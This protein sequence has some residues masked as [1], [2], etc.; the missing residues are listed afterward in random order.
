MIERC[1][2]VLQDVVDD[3]GA[4]KRRRS[5]NLVRGVTATQHQQPAGSVAVTDPS[6]S[7]AA[8]S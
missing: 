2:G 3:D 6:L 5:V 8:G 7:T 4:L 1:G